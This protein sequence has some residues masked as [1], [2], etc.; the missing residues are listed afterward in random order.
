MRDTSRERIS[1]L[2]I[3]SGVPAGELPRR[4]T[5]AGEATGR[6]R[7]VSGE[8][9]GEPHSGT[10]ACRPGGESCERV[11]SSV[12][13][14]KRAAS[15]TAGLSPKRCRNLSGDPEGE[16]LGEPRSWMLAGSA[17]ESC[18]RVASLEPWKKREASG[19]IWGLCPRCIWRN[20]SGEPDG[21]ESVGEPSRTPGGSAGESGE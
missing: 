12:P 6:L 18:E 11:A 7:C 21:E 3:L 1:K 4:R 10:P 2:R 14:K 17:G 13:S 8:S 15:E 5:P 16:S 9:V 19:E 20:L